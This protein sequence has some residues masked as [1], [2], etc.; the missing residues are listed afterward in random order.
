MAIIFLIVA[1]LHDA[2]LGFFLLGISLFIAIIYKDL[3]ITI[4]VKRP[5]NE[6]PNKPH[7]KSG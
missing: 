1:F 5:R 7:H 2:T 6:D 3:S 4:V